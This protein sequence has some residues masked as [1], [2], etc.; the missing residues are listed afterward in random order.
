M[1]AWLLVAILLAIVPACTDSRPS[2]PA[3]ATATA[4]APPPVIDIPRDAARPVSKATTSATGDLD[5]MLDRGFIRI[6]VAPSRTHFAAAKGTA[7]GRT[8]DAANALEAFIN[9]RVQP[10]RISIQ[11]IDTPEDALIPGV[12]AGTGDIAANILLTFERDDQVAFATPVHKGIRE[13][14]VTGPGEH[15]LVSLED[16]GGRTI[17]VRKSS[18]HYA[19]LLRLNAQL[20]TINRPPARI[21]IAPRTMTDEDLLEQVNAGRI[22]ATIADDYVFDLWK[23]SLEKINANPD[24][25]VS[26]DGVLAWTTRKDA[27]KLLAILND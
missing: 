3:N 1:R 16:V 25:A 4:P 9:E 19:S 20:K 13:L 14:V 26:Q 15:A 6:L 5:A 17:H 10:R 24:V 18:D 22:P 23:K 7:S 11:L 21:V 2:T 8:V 12:L 27:P